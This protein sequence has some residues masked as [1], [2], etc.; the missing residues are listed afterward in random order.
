MSAF[1]NDTEPETDYAVWG[2]YGEAPKLAGGSV[3]DEDHHPDAVL[4]AQAASWDGDAAC[5]L[6]ADKAVFE[7]AVHA[8]GLYCANLNEIPWENQ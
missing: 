6:V 5:Y 2:F 8:A 4:L 7:A 1:E 3:A